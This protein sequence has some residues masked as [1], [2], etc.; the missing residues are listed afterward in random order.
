MAK[1]SSKKLPRYIAQ[2]WFDIGRECVWSEA[3]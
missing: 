2:Q 3:V 1:I